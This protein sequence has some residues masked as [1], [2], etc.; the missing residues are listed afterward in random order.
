MPSARQIRLIHVV[1]HDTAHRAETGQPL[2]RLG[3]SPGDL[4]YF[5][6]LRDHPA[7]V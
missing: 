5:L 7:P 3:R 2:E 6:L 1:D 4:D